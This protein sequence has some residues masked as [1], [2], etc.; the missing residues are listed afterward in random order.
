MGE[1]GVMGG[2]GEDEAEQG[3]G[4]GAREVERIVALGDLAGGGTTRH[5]APCMC[6]GKPHTTHRGPM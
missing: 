1:V 6:S 2:S 4:H 3:P 5:P